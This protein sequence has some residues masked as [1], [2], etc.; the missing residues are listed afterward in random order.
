MTFELFADKGK[1]QT[2][3]VRSSADAPDHDIWPG[4]SH[5][6]L[7]QRFL[8]DDRLMQQDVVEN[9]TER[10]FR[11]LARGCVFDGFGDGDSE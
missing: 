2:R 10:I 3:E 7:F 6:E 9:G 1:A 11:I 4:V 8:A 5:I